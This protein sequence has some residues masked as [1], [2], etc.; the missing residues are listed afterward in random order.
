MNI[1]MNDRR[2]ESAI[3]PGIIQLYVSLDIC[4][5]G[6]LPGSANISVLPRRCG[7]L[8][9][10]HAALFGGLPIYTGFRIA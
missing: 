3:I 7:V 2:I 4:C 8:I 5:S 10:F 1:K 9:R 6:W